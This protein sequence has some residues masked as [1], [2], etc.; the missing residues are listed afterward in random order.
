MTWQEL[1]LNIPENIVSLKSELI[2]MIREIVGIA[3]G[4]GIS[5]ILAAIDYVRDT[6]KGDGND[7]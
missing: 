1:F 4:I 2:N 3:A 7:K 6:K 5:A